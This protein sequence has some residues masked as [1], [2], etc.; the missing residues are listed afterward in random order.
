MARRLRRRAV[1]AF[2]STHEA[3]ECE[4][5]CREAGVLG[6]IIPTPTAIRADCGL[7]WSM[8]PEEREAFEELAPGRFSF[9]GVYDLE[10]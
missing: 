3:L 6:R 1:A 9:A 7:A 5:C 2:D 8:P 10:L 4:R